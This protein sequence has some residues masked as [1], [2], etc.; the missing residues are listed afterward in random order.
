[1]SHVGAGGA[2]KKWL[3]GSGGAGSAVGVSGAWKSIKMAWVGDS[4]S[5]KLFFN[6]GI[7][8]VLTYGQDPSFGLRNGFR[9]WGVGGSHYGSLSVTDVEGETVAELSTDTG[10]N[11]LHI[12]IVG[13]GVAQDHFGGIECSVGTFDTSAATYTANDGNGNTLWEWSVSSAFPSSGSET[14]TFLL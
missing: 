8:S 14:V 2:W 13:T 9:A 11:N 6:A 12:R 10:G 3:G 1:M 7:E 5:W 4:G